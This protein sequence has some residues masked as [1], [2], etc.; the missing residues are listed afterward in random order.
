MTS[1]SRVSECDAN[2]ARHVAAWTGHEIKKIASRDMWL[3]LTMSDKSMVWVLKNTVCGSTVTVPCSDLGSNRLVARFSCVPAVSMI[4]HDRIWTD[5]DRYGVLYEPECDELVSRVNIPDGMKM[6]PDGTEVLSVV[7]A[8]EI[9]TDGPTIAFIRSLL[10]NP[11][12]L[13]PKGQK[14]CRMLVILNNGKRELAGI[15]LRTRKD[16]TSYMLRYAEQIDKEV[17]DMVLQEHAARFVQPV[18]SAASAMMHDADSAEKG[19]PPKIVV[20]E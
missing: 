7:S 20:V 6:M 1:E 13:R 12:M 9:A 2:I 10:G 14:V 19:N 17:L 4:K 15:M 16:I 5:E 8:K 3:I 11:K 18:V